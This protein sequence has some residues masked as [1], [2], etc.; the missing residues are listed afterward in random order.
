MAKI[1]ATMLRQYYPSLKLFLD[2]FFC[3]KK[4]IFDTDDLKRILVVARR[5]RE[6]ACREYNEHSRSCCL[7]ENGLHSLQFDFT[8]ASYLLHKI[9][10]DKFDKLG[11]EKGD[12]TRNFELLYVPELVGDLDER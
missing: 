6:F 10:P 2:S 12:L 9:S 11:R 1:R 4:P 5:A 7:T 8:I 3:P